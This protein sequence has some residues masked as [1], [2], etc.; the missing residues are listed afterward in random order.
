MAI[1]W[2]KY[3]SPRSFYPL[4][5]KLA[6]WFAAVAAVLAAVGLYI[7]LI[8]APTDFQ[9]GEAYRIIFIHV[10]AAWMSMFIYVVMAGYG[11]LALAFNTLLAAV[12]MRPLPPTGAL[13]QFIAL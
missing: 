5:G 11:V 12:M 7:G 8:V 9:Q 3:S 2:F 6:P 1:N 4:A 13:F 10:P